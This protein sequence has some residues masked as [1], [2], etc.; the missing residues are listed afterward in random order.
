LYPVDSFRELSLS[1]QI[2]R[3]RVS[4]LIGINATAAHAGS[5][6]V[7]SA[8]SKA[9]VSASRNSAGRS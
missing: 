8:S 5:H 1:R 7:A 2:V 3:G 4:V 9:A 6:E